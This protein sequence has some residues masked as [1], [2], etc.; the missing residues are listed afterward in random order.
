MP[1]TQLCYFPVLV[2]T[3]VTK[4]HSAYTFDSE[5][6][7][8]QNQIASSL[9]ESLSDTLHRQLETQRQ[10]L[11]KVT[12]ADRFKTHCPCI[13]EPETARH[14]THNKAS[15]RPEDLSYDQPSHNST[16]ATHDLSGSGTETYVSSCLDFDGICCE[17][18]RK[19]MA[20]LRSSFY[21]LA[22]PTVVSS[23]SERKLW[24]VCTSWLFI[25]LDLFF[26]DSDLSSEN[27]MS[28]L[29]CQHLIFFFDLK[30]PR[31]F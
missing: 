7:I 8:T 9:L 27:K 26:G 14:V 6:Q 21:K 13:K 5:D 3:F 28:A 18:K 1:F 29:V 30:K 22:W 12:S 25:Q 19:Q 17:Q 11:S 23:E 4:L 16:C 10:L 15:P 24:K 31:H 2:E 20:K